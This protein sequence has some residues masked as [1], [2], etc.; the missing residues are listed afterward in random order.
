MPDTTASPSIASG[1]RLKSGTAARLA[2]VPVSTLRVWERRYGVVAAPKT[3]T[4][5]RLYTQQDVQRLR[6]LRQLTEQG[7]AIGTIAGLAFDALSALAAGERLVKAQGRR[8]F[9]IGRQV[10]TRLPASAQC[11]MVAVH[12][13]LDDADAQVTDEAVDVLLV[14]LSSLQPSSAARVLALGTRLQVTSIVVFYTY[15]AEA[16]AAGLR[17]AGAHVQRD[18]VSARELARLVASTPKARPRPD[19]RDADAV[20]PAPRRFSDEAL[21]GLMD[22]RSTVAC[23]CP[24]H[25]AEIVLQLASFERYSAD[26]VARGP[27][28]ADLHRQLTALA[29]TARTMFEQALQR[30][31]DDEGLVLPGVR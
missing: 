23:E 31:V 8:V 30:V 20:Q 25:V 10:A 28:D 26:C 14:H 2:G 13:S 18:P 4:G 29:G 3:S 17:A 9:A 11:V 7:H 16:T 22:M 1:V 27:A 15:G 24:R 5:Q 12:D 21:A 6:L 19:E